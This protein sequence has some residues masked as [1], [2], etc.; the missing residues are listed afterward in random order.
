MRKLIW[1]VAAPGL[2]AGCS[3]YD[4]TVDYLTGSDD[5]AEVA[6]KAASEAV[7]EA[8]QSDDAASSLLGSATEAASSA[9]ADSAAAAIDNNVENSRTSISLSGVK[10]G[11]ARYQVSN[12]TGLDYGSTDSRQTFMQSSATNTNGHTVLNVGVGQRYLNEDETVM[13]GV[14]AFL[15]YN[16][17]YG[18]QRASVGAEFKTSAFE[19]TANSYSAL[20]KWEKG[21]NNNQER[22]LD[23]YE[24]EVGGQLPYMPG[25]MLYAKSWKWD[26]P[27]SSSDIKGKT[28]SLA[29]NHMIGDGLALELGRKDY[30]GLQKDEDFV[31]VKYRIMTDGSTSGESGGSIFS[32]MM[33]EKSSMRKRLLEEVRRENNI[34]VQTKF[35][36]GVSGV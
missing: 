6:G 14:N 24:V 29:F 28:Y 34:I 36:A 26:V 13:T 27:A 21:K 16:V 9:L 15:D 11:D 18:H 31:T 19:V 25:T 3:A 7:A 30:D 4:Q 8:A 23:G 17:D 20:T 33:F 2:L 35:T 5:K 12:V 1:L 32:D 10:N 22:A